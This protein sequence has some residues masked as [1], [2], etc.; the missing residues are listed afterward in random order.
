[1]PKIKILPCYLFMNK[2]SGITLQCKS[3]GVHLVPLREIL[4]TGWPGS[5]F[6]EPSCWTSD[7]RD[8]Q[9][10]RFGTHIVLWLPLYVTVNLFSWQSET[11]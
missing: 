10:V 8:L 5:T 4:D 6:S 1:M 3:P 2:F 9:D 11:D 7:C